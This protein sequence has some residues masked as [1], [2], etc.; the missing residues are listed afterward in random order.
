M[1][2]NRRISV[3]LRSAPVFALF[4]AVFARFLRKMRKIEWE[5]VPGRTIGAVAGCDAWFMSGWEIQEIGYDSCRVIF[6]GLN[7]H[8]YPV[9]AAA[10]AGDWFGHWRGAGKNG[11]FS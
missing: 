11:L 10:S 3:L 7:F 9:L 8:I 2:T 6:A 5:W 4:C 1:A